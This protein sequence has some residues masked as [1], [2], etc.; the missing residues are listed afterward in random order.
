MPHGHGLVNQQLSL[1]NVALATLASRAAVIINTQFAT[2]TNAFLCKRMRFFAQLQNRSTQDDG[3]ILVGACN[4]DADV[5]EIAAAMNERNVNGPDDVTSM[6]DQDT[7]W[8]VYQNTV[9]PMVIRGDQTFGQASPTWMNFGGK[10]GIPIQEGS[11][12]AL[13]AYNSGEGALT[14]GSTVNG[15]AQVQGVWLRG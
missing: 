15:I 3:P 7:A 5:S 4:G 6:L 12:M 10:N 1:A 14:T 9:V 2:P 8:V 11:G 13:F